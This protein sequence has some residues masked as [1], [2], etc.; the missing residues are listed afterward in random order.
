MTST[1]HQME[2]QIHSC[3][4]VNFRSPK[5]SF[6]G[7]VFCR[8]KQEARHFTDSRNMLASVVQRSLWIDE[9]CV[10]GIKGHIHF[11]S[12]LGRA[13]AVQKTRAARHHPEAHL[14]ERSEGE[15]RANA[16]PVKNM[17]LLLPKERNLSRMRNLLHCFLIDRDFVC[18]CFGDFRPALVRS[19]R[20]PSCLASRDRL[21]DQIK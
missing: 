6:N 1:G 18:C 12:I 13:I 8:F 7:M 16:T 15:T 9:K 4:M 19:C 3:N 14:E 17:V 21:I 10:L 2:D 11:I 5:D 20:S